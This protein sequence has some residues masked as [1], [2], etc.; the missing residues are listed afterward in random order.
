M[1]A[2]VLLVSQ[3]AIGKAWTSA[4]TGVLQ[5]P[6]HWRCQLG[7][8]PTPTH[9]DY[10]RATPL[11]AM[12]GA[13]EANDCRDDVDVDTVNNAFNL[14]ID[15]LLVAPPSTSTSACTSMDGVDEAASTSSSDNDA[16]LSFVDGLLLS[17]LLLEVFGSQSV[18]TTKTGRLD[19]ATDE[20]KKED[21]QSHAMLYELAAEQ[22]SS[23]QQQSPPKQQ[24]PSLLS[25]DIFGEPDVDYSKDIADELEH[26]RKGSHA[27]SVTV[28]SQSINN[29]NVPPPPTPPKTKKMFNDRKVWDFATITARLP[30][31]SETF[32]DVPTIIASLENMLELSA[33]GYTLNYRVEEARQEEENEIDWC[34][35]VQ[36]AWPPSLLSDDLVVALSFHTDEDCE[37]ALGIGKS[38]V[39]SSSTPQQQ[40]YDKIMLEGGSAFGT[41]DHPTSRLCSEWLLDACGGPARKDALHPNNNDDENNNTFRVMDY[42]SGSGIL[43]LVALLAAKRSGNLENTI[44]EGVEV[45]PVAIEASRRNSEANGYRVPEQIEFYAPMAGAPGSEWWDDLTGAETRS[46]ET[47]AEK[48]PLS[49][50]NSYNVVIAN[51]LAQPLV[52]LSKVLSLLCQKQVGRIALSGLMEDQVDA[53]L[54][55]YDPYFTDMSIVRKSRGWV[56]LEG[57]RNN[58]DVITSS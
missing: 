32:T 47:V 46:P 58:V 30:P 50:I 1:L 17:D 25:D 20:Q 28:S 18:V 11:T 51:I 44:V 8:P 56:L 29:N 35:Q 3:L 7:V 10:F 37:Q 4:R 6:L 24:K 41:G 23:S 45:D 52:S 9:H 33:T 26:Q 21:N 39:S 48:L 16:N 34:A 57:T 42:G 49:R 15:T 5:Q 31:T 19:L 54:K 27:T 13:D 2:V 40:R 14:C 53:V 12:G 43:A 55:A 22:S 38:T 36:N